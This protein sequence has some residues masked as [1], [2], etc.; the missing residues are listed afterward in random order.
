MFSGETINLFR[1]Q[2]TPFYFYDIHLLTRTL[3]EAKKEADKYQFHIHYALKANANPRIL[4]LI[5]SMGYGADCVSGNE[6]KRA[7]ECGFKQ[8]Q[9]VFA[10]VGKSDE[11]INIALSNNI[12][13]FNCESVAE[14]VVLNELAEASG[15]NA[16]IAIRINPNVNA[17][18]HHYITTGLEE[19]KFGIS[20]WELEDVLN[21]IK[22][23]A[24]IELIGLHFHIGS[25]ITDLDVFKGLCVRI[26]EIQQWFFRHQLIL[27]HI[28]VGGGLG[29]DYYKPDENPIPDFKKYFSIFN[30]F[31]EIRPKQKVHFELGRALVAQCGS[32]IT[33]V[34]YVKKGVQTHFAIVDAGMTELLRPALYHAY[35]KIENLSAAG[36]AQKYDVVG[37]ICESSDC[38]GKA[39]ELPE[40]VRGDILALRSAGAYGEVMASAYN[41]RDIVGAVY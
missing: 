36:N 16:R 17:H 11:E 7:V 31:L 5:S 3:Q 41:L 15:K 22:S 40:T 34:L 6:I 35:H 12:F 33:K 8:N 29:I 20:M 38:F 18:T 30:E 19:N 24:H 13:C 23:L 1:K 10:G 9:I 14:M 4:K 37:P 28:N 26:N 27:E 21:V 32:L 2:K 39:V 25:Q